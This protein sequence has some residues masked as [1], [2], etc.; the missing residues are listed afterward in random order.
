M[1]P[2]IKQ[3]NF[4]TELRELLKSY[5]A[6]IVIEDFSKGYI[7]NRQ[8]VIEFEYDHELSKEYGSGII[9]DLAIGTYENGK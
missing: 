2:K 4:Y 6:S 9:P 8:I 5:N 3:E 7:T 1:T